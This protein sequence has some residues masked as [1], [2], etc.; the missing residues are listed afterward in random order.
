MSTPKWPT[1]TGALAPVLSKLIAEQRAL[2][3]HPKE[4][5][6]FAR[7]DR[8]C[9]AVGHATMTLPRDLVERWTATQPRETETNRQ[10]RITLMRVLAGFMQRSELP[11]W[12]YPLHTTPRAAARYIPYIFTRQEMVALFAA[13]DRCS[14][15]PRSPD[16]GPVLSTL[17]RVLYGTGL[18]AGEALQLQQRDVD[19]TNGTLSIRNAKGHKDRCIPLHPAL[20]DR[21]SG[22]LARQSHA[23]PTTPVFPNRA[24]EPYA[25]VTIYGYFRRF[26]AAAGMAHG[27]RGKGPRLHD[28]RHTY[29]VHCLQQWIADG[30]DLT[31]ALPYLSA[32]LGHTGLQSTQDYL[33]LTAELYPAVVA[34]IEQQLGFVIPRGD[35]HDH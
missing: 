18:R 24:G 4:A 28:L 11:A 1:F 22:Y 16:R 9:Q 26:L 30:V 19:G 25:V 35:D 23:L 15:D 10:R 17:F 20:T 6:D 29:S 32:Y 5:Q 13:V 7:F 2:G 33:R 31:V 34:A 27:G 12:M 21:L 14:E 3:Y 8:F